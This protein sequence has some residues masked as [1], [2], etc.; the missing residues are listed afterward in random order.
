MGVDER[1][2]GFRSDRHVRHDWSC[3][4]GQRSRVSKLW[5][6]QLD[7]HLWKSLAVR[8]ERS[9]CHHYQFWGLERPLEIQYR[10][11]PM[12]LGKRIKRCQPKWELRCTKYGGF[13]QR[14]GG[15]G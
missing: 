3:G 10:Q 7:G 12:D 9:P 15:A 5:S 8:R 14:P 1:V 4:C 2:K 13:D 11:W 6:S